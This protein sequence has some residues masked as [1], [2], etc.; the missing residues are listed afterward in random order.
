MHD[1]SYW[2]P[3]VWA[4]IVVFAISTYV[5]LDGFDLGVGMLFA[6]EKT[7]NHRNIMVNTIAPV[8]D[9]NETWMVLGGAVL[10]G[11]FPGGYSTLLPAFYIPI[12]VMLLSLIFRGVSFEYRSLAHTD[13]QKKFWN[14]VFWIGSAIATFC[15]GAILGGYVQGISVTNGVFSG[16]ALDWLSPFSILCGLS[17][18]CGYALLGATWLVWRT[19]DE[20]EEKSRNWAKLLSVAM[21][22]CIVAVSA[23]TPFLQAPYLRR[24]IVWP[25]IIFVSPV[26]VLVLVTGIVMWRSLQKGGVKSPFFCAII[27]FLLSLLGLAITIWPYAVPPSLKIWDI[28]SPVSSQIFELVG[29]AFLI[30]IT[31]AY[32][33]YSYHIFRGKVTKSDGYH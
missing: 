4:A 22:L 32:T 12:T 17:V 28:A 31:L 8:W 33:L 21:F 19:S 24:W 14:S 29:T 11:V 13:S 23:W 26:P 18:M 2:L 6:I 16:H 5:V 1:L 25:N 15:Q 7:P 30:P 27:W 3:L 9:G 10:F 20:L